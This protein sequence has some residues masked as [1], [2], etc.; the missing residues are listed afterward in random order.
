MMISF[1]TSFFREK[2]GEYDNQER[3]KRPFLLI[4]LSNKYLVY[5]DLTHEP[6]LIGSQSPALL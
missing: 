6:E 3:V 4:F 2:N 5:T 1:K